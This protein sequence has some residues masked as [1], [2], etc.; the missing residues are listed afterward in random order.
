M[1]DLPFRGSWDLVVPGLCGLFHLGADGRIRAPPDHPRRHR[2]GLQA[3]E[4]Q[5]GEQRQHGDQDGPADHLGEVALGEPV[6]QVAAEPAQADESGQ[7]GGGHHLHRRSTDAGHD[8][9]HGHRQLDL[10]QHLASAHAHALGRLADV[11]VDRADPD[12]AVGD[13]RGH[14]QGGQGDQDRDDAEADQGEHQDDDAQRGD[15]PAQVGQVDGEQGAPAG[16]ADEDPDGQGDGG[17]DGRGQQRVPEMLEGAHR[18]P[19]RPAPL[20]RVGQPGEDL[21]D[22][23]HGATP[24]R[25]G[26]RG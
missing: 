16:V 14:G 1:D 12:V 11:A 7:G 3:A 19:V 13:D 26:P 15:G 8:Q 21:V 22:D 17:G 6:D 20:G 10:P 18:D 9:R 23:V 2:Q 5:L 25:S 4:H 24:R